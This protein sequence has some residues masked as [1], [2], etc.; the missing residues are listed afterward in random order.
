MKNPISS[1][2]Y[3]FR[4]GWGNY[5]TFVFTAIHSLTTTY[6]LVIEK[7]P[8]FEPFFPSI[9]HY[10]LITALLL[11]PIISYLGYVYFKKSPQLRSEA[12]IL[13]ESNPHWKRIRE[14]CELCKDNHFILLRILIKKYNN[15]LN[16]ED[17][18]KLKSLID[19]LNSHKKQ[20]T[21]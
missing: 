13:F 14:N 12:D 9:F 18:S 20:K 5:F 2:W 16:N 17:I 3:Y 6:Y 21:L 4:I 11:F 8:I 1:I 10:A 7:F 15:N 19:R